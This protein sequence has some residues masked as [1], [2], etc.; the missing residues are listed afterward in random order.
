VSLTER[1]I[2]LVRHPQTEANVAARYMG[3]QDSPITPHGQLQLR[4]LARTVA[5]WEPDEAYVSPLERTQITARAV[6][7]ALVP[8]TVLDDLAEID[9]GD[10]EGYT[11]AELSS[12]GVALDYT[13]G[14]P[15]APGGE[16]SAEFDA[17]VR[18]AAS[19]IEAGASRIVVVTHGG[20]VR[21]LLTQWLQLPL[22]AGWRLAVPN[23][24]VAVVALADGTGV[25]ES[26]TPP[27][28]LDG[29]APGR[30][31]WHL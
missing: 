17:R 14:G 22:E 25:L 13:S 2:M 5:E 31:P 7:P 3:R 30:R 6:V 23:A 16:T 8:M 4:W 21:R 24:V 1:R 18:R 27:P 9:F 29:S 11:Y 15:I 20:V 12:R 28:A 19:A 10:A 26:L